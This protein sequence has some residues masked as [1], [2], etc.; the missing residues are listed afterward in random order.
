M[1]VRESATPSSGQF[2][3]MRKLPHR[4]AEVMYRSNDRAQAQEKLDSQVAFMT[5]QGMTVTLQGG[6]G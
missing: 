1:W 6:E 2:E 4:G 5:G 3:V